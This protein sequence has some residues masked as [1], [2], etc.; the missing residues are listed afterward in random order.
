MMVDIKHGCSAECD[1]CRTEADYAFCEAHL[2]SLRNE[3]YDE[4]RKDGLA[5]AKEKAV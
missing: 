5:E 1:D 3:S 4:G 2:V